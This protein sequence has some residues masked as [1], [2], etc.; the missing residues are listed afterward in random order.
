MLT[1]GCL[2]GSPNNQKKRTIPWFSFNSSA[3][4]QKLPMSLEGKFEPLRPGRKHNC[5]WQCLQVTWRRIMG[6]A[7]HVDWVNLG[8]NLGCG[9]SSVFLP[10]TIYTY[11]VYIYTIFHVSQKYP[12]MYKYVLFSSILAILVAARFVS[13]VMSKVS[14]IL[15]WGWLKRRRDRF[16]KGRF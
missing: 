15:T 8:W 5:S 9:C 11:C 16:G 13:Q 6:L 10:Y 2:L 4:F 1:L 3:I 14:H 12:N 7:E